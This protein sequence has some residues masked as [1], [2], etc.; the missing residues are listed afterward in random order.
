MPDDLI[1]KGPKDAKRVN[2]N[3]PYEVRYWCDQFNCTE[4]ELRNAVK[5]AGVMVDKVRAYFGG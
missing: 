4:E 5:R 3:E 1:D 2:V